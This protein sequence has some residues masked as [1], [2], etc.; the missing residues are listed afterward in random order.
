LLATD[1][2]SPVSKRLPLAEYQQ[3]LTTYMNNMTSG[4]ILFVMNGQ[5]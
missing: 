2:Y 3:A 1:L 5:I 4:K